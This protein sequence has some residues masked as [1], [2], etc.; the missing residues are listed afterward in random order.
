MKVEPLETVLIRRTGTDESELLNFLADAIE[1]V[2]NIGTHFI[3]WEADR[4]GAS[5][6]KTPLIML[7]RHILE[8]GDAISIL[9]RSSSV[10]PCKAMLR[11]ILETSLQIEYLLKD[12]ETRGFCYMVCHHNKM[13]KQLKRM[14]ENSQEQKDYFNQLKNKSYTDISAND[15]SHPSAQNDVNRLVNLINSKDYKIYQIE[16]LKTST[17][18][19]DNGKKNKNPEWYS[20]FGGPKSCIELAE[21]L[22]RKDFYEF[23]YRPFSSTVHGSDLINSNLQLLSNGFA[24]ASPI[25]NNDSASDFAEIAIQ[26]LTENQRTILE[27]FNEGI[28]QYHTHWYASFRKEYLEPLRKY[29]NSLNAPSTQ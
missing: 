26:L 12:P 18:K 29:N 25:R 4:G 11:S 24:Q 1:Q 9:L 28:K 5:V 14:V 10:D 13:I 17:Q 16:Y 8:M 21:N 2:I 6:E 22:K 23:M 3:K 7:Y 27:R 19:N 20:L 15:F